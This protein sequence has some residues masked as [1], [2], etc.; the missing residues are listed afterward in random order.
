MNRNHKALE[1]DKVLEM[2]A[3]ETTC[4]EAAS[5]ALELRP[6]EN[7]EDARVLL[8]Q[9]DDAFVLMAKFGAPS[10][11]GLRNIVNAVRRAEAGGALNLTELLGVE[12]TLKVIRGVA[13]WRNK[14]ASIKTTLDY[15]FDTLQPNKY[16]EEK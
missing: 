6:A 5:L 7:I 2:L 3:A 12:A 16:L 8:Q 4:E 11:Y 13:D 14:S 9:T 1:L 15:R 10:F